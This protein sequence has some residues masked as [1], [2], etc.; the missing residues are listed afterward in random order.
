MKNNPEIHIKS[1]FFF[2]FFVVV[3]FIRKISLVLPSA[4]IIFS[5]HSFRANERT[6]TTHTQNAELNENFIRQ[7]QEQHYISHMNGK[8]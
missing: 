6:T 7:L 4:E 8:Q 5:L 1:L 3:R 2:Y